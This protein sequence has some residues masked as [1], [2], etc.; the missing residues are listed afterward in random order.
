LFFALVAVGSA[1]ELTP[2]TYDSLSAGKVVFLKFFA[3]WCGHCKKM[4]PDWDKLMTEFADS[5]V[6]LVADVDCTAGGKPLCDA[7]GVQGF[8]TLKFG[9]PSALEDYSG[10]RDMASLQKFAQGLQPSCGPSNMELCSDDEKADLQKLFDLSTE[11]LDK[12]IADGEKKIEDAE[13]EFKAAVEKL[14]ATYKQLQDDKDAATAE[15]K[16]SGLG[17]LKAVQAAKAKKA[18]AGDKEEL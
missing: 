2:D 7:N 5:T 9:D 13:T 1:V 17:K 8:P 4:K 14:Q 10:A 12:Q 18:A 6:T 3:P 11:D 15:V 16:A